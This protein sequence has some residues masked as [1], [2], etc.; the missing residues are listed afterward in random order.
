MTDAEL[1]QA[2]ADLLALLPDQAAY[3]AEAE[4]LLGRMEAERGWPRGKAA[5]VLDLA[6][7]VSTL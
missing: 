4:R 6:L 3:L 7:G 2:A 1:D 5:V